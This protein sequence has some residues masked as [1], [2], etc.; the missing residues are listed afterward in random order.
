[1]ICT[2][3]KC[4]YTFQSNALPDRCPDCGATTLPFHVEA[5]HLHTSGLIPAVRKATAV[6]IAEYENLRLVIAAEW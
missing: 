3:D 4:K 2:C 6:E 1:M 5:P